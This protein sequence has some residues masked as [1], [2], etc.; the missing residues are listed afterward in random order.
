MELMYLANPYIPNHL[1]PGFL[2]P[3]DIFLTRFKDLN[4]FTIS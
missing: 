2:V 1:N 3:K 4:T